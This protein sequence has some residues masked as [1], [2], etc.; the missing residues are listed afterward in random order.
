MW[1][2]GLNTGQEVCITKQAWSRCGPIHH[3]PIILRGWCANLT[4]KVVRQSVRSPSA[5]KPSATLPSLPF[6]VLLHA[7]QAQALALL[8]DFSNKT[9]FCSFSP[10]KHLPCL[11]QTATSNC[12]GHHQNPLGLG[13]WLS[14]C[15]V[16]HET[17]HPYKRPDV[18]AH[19]CNHSSLAEA[20]IGRAP[21]LAA[22]V[23]LVSSNERP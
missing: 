8:S 21:G 2:L 19:T 18:A 7:V 10:H 20:E 22:L 14:Q 17:P 3:W 1:S 5:A 11:S 15:N 9:T 12:M 13:R 16:C 6:S 4:C 23:E